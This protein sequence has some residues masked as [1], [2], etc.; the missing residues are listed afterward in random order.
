LY[1]AKSHGIGH[2][3]EYNGNGGG[4]RFQGFGCLWCRDD[5]HIGTESNQIGN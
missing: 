1:E 5:E 4:R 3:Y 2:S